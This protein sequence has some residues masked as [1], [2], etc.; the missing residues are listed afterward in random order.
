M[1]AT[2]IKKIFNKLGVTVSSVSIKPG[3]IRKDGKK[4][5]KLEI[6]LSNSNRNLINF[7]RNVG[8]NYA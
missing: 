1:F 4:T 7:L 3:N 6:K 2:Q 5:I 8:F